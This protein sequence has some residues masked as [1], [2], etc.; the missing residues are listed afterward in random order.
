MLRDAYR[1]LGAY[2]LERWERLS[3]FF[4]AAAAAEAG[5]VRLSPL[6]H[7]ADR[8]RMITELLRQRHADAPPADW[9]SRLLVA[10]MLAAFRVWLEDVRTSDITDPLQHLD[11]ILAAA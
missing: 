10:R 6:V 4:A 8:E 3:Q 1:R 11:T 7:L 2:V 5:T 9:R